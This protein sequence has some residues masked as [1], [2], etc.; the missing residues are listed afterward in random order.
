MIVFFLLKSAIA[1]LMGKRRRNYSNF[2]QQQQRTQQS[3]QP[4]NQK[5]RVIGYQKKKF[6]SSDIEDADFVEIKD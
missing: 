2:R 4:E 5:D 3:K 1:F 6:E